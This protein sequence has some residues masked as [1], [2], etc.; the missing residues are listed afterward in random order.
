MTDVPYNTQEWQDWAAEVNARLVP[1]LQ[2]SAASI[3]LFPSDGEGD[4]KYAVELGLS[5]MMNKPILLI[6]PPGTKVPAKMHKVADLMI[7]ADLKAG[8][9]PEL[10]AAIHEFLNNLPDENE[11]VH[12]GVPADS[13][14]AF[15]DP[16]ISLESAV[17]QAIGAAS[18]CWE[19]LHGAGTFDSTKAKNIGDALLARIR[20]L[21]GRPPY[22]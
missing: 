14:F 4:V 21:T 13:S 20:E 18:V 17:F 1:M 7:S 22:S 11:V 5:L 9:P 3:S 2:E 16:N 19:N 6:V 12:V 8:P 10:Q 15:D